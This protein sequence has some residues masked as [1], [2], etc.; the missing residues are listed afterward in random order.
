MAAF[1]VTE[2]SPCAASKFTCSGV[3]PRESP[4]PFWDLRLLQS[5]QIDDSQESTA[6][7]ELCQIDWIVCKRPLISLRNLL[8]R[9]RGKLAFEICACRQVDDNPFD[10]PI[11]SNAPPVIPRGWHQDYDAFHKLEATECLKNTACP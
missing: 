5:I 6:A 9:L 10:F 7:G 3:R 11:T 8:L 2:Y 1:A 4:I